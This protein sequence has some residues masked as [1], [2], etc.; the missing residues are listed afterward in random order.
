[1]LQIALERAEAKLGVA[2]EMA[3]DTS[4]IEV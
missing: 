4:G 1:L 2:I 3:S